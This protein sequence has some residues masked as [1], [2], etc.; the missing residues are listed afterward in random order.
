[1]KNMNSLIWQNVPQTLHYI[2]T[3]WSPTHHTFLCPAHLEYDFCHASHQE[4]ESILLLQT[5]QPLDLG[6]P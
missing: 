5:L 1:M 3:E 2:A 4:I 6:L